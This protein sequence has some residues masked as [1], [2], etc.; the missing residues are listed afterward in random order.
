MSGHPKAD[1]AAAAISAIY[2][3]DQLMKGVKANEVQNEKDADSHFIKAAIGAA[4]AIGALELLKR[5]K[6]AVSHEVSDGEGR[7]SENEYD[8]SMDIAKH[9]KQ[10][11]VGTHSTEH[12]PNPLRH[13]ARLIQD[14]AAAYRLGRKI[15]G[16]DTQGIVVLVA[17]A[18][19]GL[20]LLHQ[21]DN[22]P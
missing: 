1:M 7:Q 10:V 14:S 12:K 3:G 17:E 2:A 22:D 16:H 15:M 21:K 19:G 4:V 9:E 11:Q 20:G 6:E 8:L 5:D 18:I 13:S